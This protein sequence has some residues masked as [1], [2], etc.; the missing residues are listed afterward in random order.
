MHLIYISST[1]KKLNNIYGLNNT[2]RQ[3]PTH[4]MFLA[5]I[6]F[7]V[8]ISTQLDLNVAPEIIALPDKYL[9]DGSGVIYRPQN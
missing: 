3:K 6:G 4:G 8:G 1:N 9:L 2:A 7:Q 5:T